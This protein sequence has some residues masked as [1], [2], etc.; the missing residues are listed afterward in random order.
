MTTPVVLIVLASYV[1]LLLELV[2][3]RVPSVASSLNIW[4]PTPALVAAYSPRYRRLLDLA[5]PLKLLMFVVPLLVVYAV[6]AYPLLVAW[7]GADPL[8]DYAFTPSFATNASGVALLL[9]GRALALKSALTIRRDNDQAESFHLHTT[10]P[11]RWSRNPGLIGMYAFVAGLWLI[12]PSTAMLAG[13]LVY[14][15]HMDIRVRMEED[16][17]GNRF[18]PAYAEYRS[19]TGRYLP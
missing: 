15:V 10:G 14:V 18:G 19:R 12:A 5:K 4:S 8:D 1:S 17:L 16:F 2:V 9:A 11:F 13:I 6:F 3:L 7:Y